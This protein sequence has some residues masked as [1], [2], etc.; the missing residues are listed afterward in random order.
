MKKSFYLL[1]LF[2]ALTANSAIAQ[3][4]G[5]VRNRYYE[6][7]SY[8]DDRGDYRWQV[9]ERRVW[10]PG[11]RTQGVF[12]IGGRNVPGHYETRTERVRVYTNKSRSNHYYDNKGRGK[13]KHP[14]GMPPGQRK[15]MKKHR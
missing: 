10:V 14:H 15:K 11:Y 13:S 3:N 1:A 9:V 8:N 5:E 4:R 12:G 6:R 2:A 7:G